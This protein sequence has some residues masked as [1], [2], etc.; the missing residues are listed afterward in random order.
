M[1]MRR[2]KSAVALS[3]SIA[4]AAAAC[5]LQ[6]GGTIVGENPDGSNGGDGTVG[7]DGATDD[8]SSGGDGSATGDSGDAA[9]DSG[10]DAS[11][12][13]FLCGASPVA[14]CQTDCPGFPNNCPVT[15]TCVADC[16]ANCFDGV[17]FDT[18]YCN[19]CFSD[20]GA[21]VAV[22]VPADPTSVSACLAGFS[23]CPCPTNVSQCPGA[24]QTCENNECFACGE[25]DAGND[26]H[27]CKGGTGGKNCDTA[28]NATDHLRCH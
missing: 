14:Q 23:R 17:T 6:D 12:S 28:G 16:T 11:G 2:W 26:G 18:R 9:T 8:G 24:Y 20:G 3:F 19:A 13:T 27:G 22:C 25:P 7:G 5:S 4:C 21:A 10:S 15:G 1:R